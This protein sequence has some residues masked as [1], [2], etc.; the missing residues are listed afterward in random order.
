MLFFCSTFK[1]V[2]GGPEA[3]WRCKL[4]RVY[5]GLLLRRFFFII[6]FF[7]K[8]LKLFYFF[9]R[10]KSRYHCE[11]IFFFNLILIFLCRFMTRY[12]LM[13]LA[14]VAKTF[15]KWFVSMV[16]LFEKKIYFHSS[17]LKLN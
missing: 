7:M 16:F 4:E 17:K 9:I 15:R 13:P 2:V 5:Y 3:N 6:I 11:N 12:T 14:V 8:I 10:E 1:F